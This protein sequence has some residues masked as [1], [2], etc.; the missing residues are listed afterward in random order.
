MGHI[1]DDEGP[2][3]I[4]SR[5]MDRLPSG[6][7]LMLQ[8]GTTVSQA[9]ADALEDYNESGAIPY[10]L[11]TPEEIVRYFDGLELVEPGVIP[12]RVATDDR[13]SRAARRREQ[14]PGGIGHKNSAR[15]PD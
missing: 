4:V 9:N 10:N 3:A 13:A 15:P 14:V 12:I 8:D 1:A 2:H 5:L 11:R 6:S 7:Y